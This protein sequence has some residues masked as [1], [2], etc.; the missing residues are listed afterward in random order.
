[1]ASECVEKV[2]NVITTSATDA[3]ELVVLVLN[4]MWGATG[5]E[6]FSP[7]IV[8]FILVETAARGSP[9]SAMPIFSWAKQWGLSDQTG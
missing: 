1:M 5:C 9:S 7:F 4:S 3:I 8:V 6:V 2:R